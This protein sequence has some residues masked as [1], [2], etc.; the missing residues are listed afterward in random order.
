MLHVLTMNYDGD[1]PFQARRIPVTKI[2]SGEILMGAQ[3]EAVQIQKVGKNA[4]VILCH[5][6]VI[7]AVDMPSAGG[8]MGTENCW[9]SRSLFQRKFVWRSK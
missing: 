9:Y 6:E 7:S 2:I 3:M 5:G 8:T 4:V 1:Y